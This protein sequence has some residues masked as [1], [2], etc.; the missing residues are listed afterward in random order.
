MDYDCFMPEHAIIRL[1]KKNNKQVY[2]IISLPLNYLSL[3]R[4]LIFSEEELVLT[5]KL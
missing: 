4:S 3:Y 2:E 1:S 5:K